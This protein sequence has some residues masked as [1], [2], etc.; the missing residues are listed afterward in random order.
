MLGVMFSST[1]TI[2]VKKYIYFLTHL[3]FQKEY[4]FSRDRKFKSM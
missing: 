4:V 3:L 1:E 2:S